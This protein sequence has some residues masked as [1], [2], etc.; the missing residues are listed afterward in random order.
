MQ[1]LIGFSIIV[2][3]I[4]LCFNEEVF[5][6]IGLVILGLAINRGA[7]N[8]SWISFEFGDGGDSDGD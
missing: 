2:A 8:D 6:G 5:I 4:Y 7:D 3:G 1:K